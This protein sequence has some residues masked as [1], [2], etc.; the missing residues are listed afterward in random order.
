VWVFHDD[1][2]LTGPVLELQFIWPLAFLILSLFFDLVHYVTGAEI[3]YNFFLHHEKNTD[4]EDH[5][6]IKAPDWKRMLVSSFFYIKIFWT[7]AAYISL[8][9]ILFNKLL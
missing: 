5:D 4:V 6:N 9:T 7:V 1:N 3:W 8:I 2:P